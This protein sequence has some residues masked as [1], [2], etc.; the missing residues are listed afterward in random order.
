MG[1]PVQNRFSSP[2][3]AKRDLK[4][5][6]ILHQ[7]KVPLR[8]F[9][10]TFMEGTSSTYI[11]DMFRSWSHDP[12]SV[13]SSWASYFKNIEAGVPS[14]Q[15]FT[16]P[17]RPGTQLPTFSAT[18]RPGQN[19]SLDEISENMRLMLLIRSYQIKGNISFY[20]RL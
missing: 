15:A 11:E 16:A 14:G 1:T 20:V 2:R 7:E 6:K 5:S 19:V 4:Y 3:V 10:D 17:P 9:A 13:H 12:S 8:Q 18:A